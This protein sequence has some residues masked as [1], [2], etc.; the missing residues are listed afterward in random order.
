MP[1][2]NLKGLSTTREPVPA[3]SYELT[4]TGQKH[5]TVKS[6]EYEGTARCNVEFTIDDGD[7]AGR[8][9]YKSYMLHEDFLYIFKGDMLILGVDDKLLEDDEVESEDIAK[10]ALGEK[11]TGEVSINEWKDAK[12]ED[13]KNNRVERIHEPGW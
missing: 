6:G 9:V 13:R 4:V 2:L 5:D 8:K 10:A 3:D 1:K 7:F 11:C 12:G